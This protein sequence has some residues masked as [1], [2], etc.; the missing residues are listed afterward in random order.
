VRFPLRSDPAFGLEASRAVMN[1]ARRVASQRIYAGAMRIAYIERIERPIEL[2]LLKVGPARALHLPGESMVEY[3]LY[4]QRL[5]PGEFVAV[6]AYG[7][8]GPGYICT[9]AAF[10]EGGYEPTE[11]MVDPP[12][13]TVYK[14]AIRALVGVE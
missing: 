11:S 5:M 8:C 13:E 6:A 12:G 2:S 10:A 14:A 9:E 4:A 3:Q 7:D 1:D